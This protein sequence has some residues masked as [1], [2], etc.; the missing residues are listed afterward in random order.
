MTMIVNIAH[1]H[2]HWFRNRS[3]VLVFG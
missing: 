3:C 1:L 2:F